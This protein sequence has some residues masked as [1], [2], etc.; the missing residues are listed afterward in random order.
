IVGGFDFGDTGGGNKSGFESLL[1]LDGSPYQGVDTNHKEVRFPPEKRGKKGK[2]DSRLWSGREGGGMPKKQECTFRRA[3]V[4]WVDEKVD[5]YYYD[6]R[7]VI[8]TVDVLKDEQPEKHK[9]LQSL[10]QSLNMIEWLNPGS[11][12]FYETVYEAEKYLAEQMNSIE[13]HHD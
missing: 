11:L 3:D 1:F 7:A 2:V 4:A 13:K 6:A 10:N 5:K 12:E 8:E 9:L